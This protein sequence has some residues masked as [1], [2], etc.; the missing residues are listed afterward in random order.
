MAKRR[1]RRRGVDVSD[2]IYQIE[3]EKAPF[4]AWMS[5]PRPSGV[6][7][8]L[9]EVRSTELV[10]LLKKR[11]RALHQKAG[12]INAARR[13]SFMA[14]HV[15]PGAVFSLNEADLRYLGIGA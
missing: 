14:R 2:V 3:P 6:S 15:K 10:L 11:A 7:G 1:K 12:S 8:L 13:L 9:V 4:H 5:S